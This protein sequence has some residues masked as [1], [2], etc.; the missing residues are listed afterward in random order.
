MTATITTVSIVTTVVVQNILAITQLRTKLQE[1]V[2]ENVRNLEPA[3]L[4][5]SRVSGITFFWGG[6]G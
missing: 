6:L 5:D 4:E 3:M 1:N 2:L